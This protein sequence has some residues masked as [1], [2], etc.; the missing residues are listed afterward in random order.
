MRG[1]KRDGAGR[2]SSDLALIRH[3]VLLDPETA[4]FL[5][6]YGSGNLSAGI[7]HLVQAHRSKTTGRG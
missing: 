6:T 7:R 3:Q 4:Q 2:P 1:G 5:K